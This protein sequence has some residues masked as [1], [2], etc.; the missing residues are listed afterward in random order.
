MQ[1][2]GLQHFDA[3]EHI[4]R[5]LSTPFKRLFTT[6]RRHARCPDPGM[7]C[8]VSRAGMSVCR[9]RYARIPGARYPGLRLSLSSPGCHPQFVVV[10]LSFYTRKR[11]VFLGYLREIGLP[12]TEPQGAY[13]VMLDVSSLGFMR[14]ADAAEWFVRE[15]GVA[16]VPGSSFFREP[17][18][19]FVRF[20]FAKR[21]ETLHA[22]GERLRRVRELA[23]KR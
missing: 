11:D 19:N 4:E 9:R 23:S 7:E 16:G 18:H 21:E 6:A 8:E 5:V 17:V 3:I 20:H 22:A 12:F 10:G 14:D 13:Y 2:G 15:I 1:A